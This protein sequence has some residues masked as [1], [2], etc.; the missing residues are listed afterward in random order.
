MRVGRAEKAMQLTVITATGRREALELLDGEPLTGAA[1]QAAV[2]RRL[3]LPPWLRLVHSGQPLADDEAVSRLKDGGEVHPQVHQPPIRANL[4]RCSAQ[5][6]RTL[7]TACAH[8]LACPLPPA[9]L[10]L[11]H[12][13][14]AD[15]ILAVV[16]PRAPPKAVRELAAGGG[17]Q[18][19]AADDDDPLRLRLPA[20]AP[21]WQRALAHFLQHRLRLPEALLALL[22]HVG[23]RFWLG[24][25]AWVAGARLAAAYEVGPVY[26]VTTIF[27]AIFL[28]LGQRQEGEWSAYSIFNAGTRR[29][30]GQMTAEDLDGQL[31]R[32]NL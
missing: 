31:R 16:A 25:V 23:P 5:K 28:N 30:P 29:L 1:L 4:S 10:S 7:P 3:G 15:S 11:A 22:L 12:F 26:V 27:L 18:D 20:N 21:R 17:G 13:P 19:D 8:P 24:L 2:A 14:A 9:L 6:G 32:G